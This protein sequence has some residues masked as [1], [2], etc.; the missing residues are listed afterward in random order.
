ML[1]APLICF[2]SNLPPLGMLQL[3]FGGLLSRVWWGVSGWK[4]RN[5]L[6]LL[7]K[8]CSACSEM[9]TC[10]SVSRCPFQHC[11]A[12]RH[13]QTG[14]LG[15]NLVPLENIYH[16]QAWLQLS[17]NPVLFTDPRQASFTEGLVSLNDD[18]VSTQ[19]KLV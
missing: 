6:A 11:C 4:E 18:L 5:L 14:H 12:F 7:F 3:C 9:P 1:L 16:S 15:Q 2:C 13:S 10:L 8:E 19:H 17:M